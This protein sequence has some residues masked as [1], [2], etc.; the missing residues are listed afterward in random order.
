MKAAAA[1]TLPAAAPWVRV[2][3]ASE[4]LAT[5]A[6]RVNGQRRRASP[7]AL[8]AAL[9]AVTLSGQRG[10]VV[11]RHWGVARPGGAC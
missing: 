11:R 4:P 1:A 2:T 5:G 7:M 6:T 9:V 8:P 3:S 10:A